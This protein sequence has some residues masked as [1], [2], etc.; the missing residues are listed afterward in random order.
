MAQS[1]TQHTLLLHL[2]NELRPAEANAFEHLLIS[3]AELQQEYLETADVVA[4]LTAEILPE[5]DP[6]RLQQLLD[7]AQR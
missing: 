3:D 1:S 2:F 4:A 6:V 7:Y 5:P